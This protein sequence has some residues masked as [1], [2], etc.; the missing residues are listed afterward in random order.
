MSDLAP[1]PL[2]SHPSNRRVL[3]DRAH[4]LVALQTQMLCGQ[5]R[6]VAGLVDGRCPRNQ[7]RRFY[8]R[9]KFAQSRILLLPEHSTYL[10][11]CVLWGQLQLV[12]LEIAAYMEYTN[13]HYRT[14]SPSPD[15]TTWYVG[16]VTTEET[17]VAQLHQHG[18]PV[19]HLQSFPIVHTNVP[20]FVSCVQP[21][22]A[23]TSS[24]LPSLGEFDIFDARVMD[25]IDENDA[26]FAM[27]SSAY[28]IQTLPN[29]S[30]N[31]IPTALVL[32]SPHERPEC[33]PAAR[34]H[35]YQPYP[36]RQDCSSSTTRDDAGPLEFQ[37]P[38]NVPEWSAALAQC[39]TLRLLPT[40]APGRLY[41]FPPT[42]IF[43]VNDRMKRVRMI[44]N[45]LH[46]RPAWLARVQGMDSD[47]ASISVQGWRDYLTH[48]PERGPLNRP[49]TTF[50]GRK[51]QKKAKSANTLLIFHELLPDGV[52]PLAHFRDY[53]WF[54]HTLDH[55]EPEEQLQT[56]RR[57]WNRLTDM[58]IQYPRTRS[59]AP[60]PLPVAE[61]S[62]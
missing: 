31:S 7:L 46:V 36:K 39:H 43:L 34:T 33:E 8:Q 45:W 13:I 12:A 57:L 55:D 49:T 47:E 15:S 38:E 17:I 44:M 20:P 53:A 22:L 24:E 25:A 59:G 1:D 26:R 58:E 14:F 51:A 56:T 54:G 16:A 40:P 3:T 23:P 4:G 41:L 6:Y 28:A 32:P 52:P 48:S 37:L 2:Q 5:A 61:C 60:D 42:H 29:S 19:W 9:I 30:R 62:P 50:T 11:L 35:R 10:Q 18:V 21:T 27:D